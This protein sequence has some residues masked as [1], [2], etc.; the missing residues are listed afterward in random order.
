MIDKSS[1]SPHIN[2]DQEEQERI[3]SAA[4]YPLGKRAIL[5]QPWETDAKGQQINPSTDWTKK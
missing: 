3:Q 1:I 5:E 4:K 2:K